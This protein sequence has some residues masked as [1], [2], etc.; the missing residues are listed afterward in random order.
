MC[1][2]G[3]LKWFYSL[4]KKSLMDAVIF[5][6]SNDS[7]NPRFMHLLSVKYKEPCSCDIPK[8]KC[9]TEHK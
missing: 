2:G 1:L 6:L 7:V 9:P 4:R 5:C 3:K 8:K